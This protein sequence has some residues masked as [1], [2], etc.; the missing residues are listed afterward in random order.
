MKA[1]IQFFL[2][3]TSKGKQKP[4][5]MK[6]N[7]VAF[8]NNY[9]MYSTGEYVNKSDWLESKMYNIAGHVRE[10]AEE[11][12]N[13]NENL[14]KFYDAFIEAFKN[15]IT[16]KGK[17]KNILNQLKIPGYEDPNETIDKGEKFKTIIAFAE[18]SIIN[19]PVY[20]SEAAKSIKRM[21]KGTIKSKRQAIERLKDFENDYKYRVTFE[22]CDQNF[23]KQFFEFLAK[24]N[25]SPG[26]R[27]RIVKDLRS[28]LNR[29]TREG[30]EVCRDYTIKGVAPVE[31]SEQKFI[32]LNENEIG[33]IA[34]L[35]LKGNNALEN[36]RDWLLLACGTGLRHSDLVCLDQSNIID[37]D[38][39]K[40]IR[41]RTKKTGTLV[42]I[43]IIIDM[44]P[45]LETMLN[46][47]GWK[48]PSKISSQRLN[49]NF[50]TIGKLAGLNRL[51]TAR[52]KQGNISIMIGISTKVPVFLVR[53]LML[54]P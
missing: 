1:N 21:T 8:K 23:W 50:K 41:I 16:D 39:G 53:I 9:F 38:Y 4:I 35:V 30:Y 40:S 13:I 44:F 11:A 46:N 15:R 10:D 17:L 36:S 49:K 18:D 48:F 7:S 51:V 24:R 34:S 37:N 20:Y 31:R 3:P 5:M 32:Y 6:C 19:E 25:L 27:G 52:V 42:E 29:A 47:R 43:P 12:K 14:R 22:N 2:N 45:W 54:L 28:F 26:T 33:Q